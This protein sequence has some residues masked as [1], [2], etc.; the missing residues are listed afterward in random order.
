MTTVSTHSH[1]RA[2]RSVKHDNKAIL[3]YIQQLRSH[4]QY[5]LSKADRM[6]YIYNKN[7]QHKHQHKHSTLN[8]TNSANGSSDVLDSMIEHDEYDE[9]GYID[10]DNI[11]EVAQHEACYSI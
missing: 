5:L 3:L 4:A 2:N 10:D 8:G 9:I 7:K 1:T 6:Q 11:N